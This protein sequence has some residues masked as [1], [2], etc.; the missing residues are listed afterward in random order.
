MAD[1]PL[2]PEA[3]DTRPHVPEGIHGRKGRSNEVP[4]CPVQ[5]LFLGHNRGA[6][7]VAGSV[8]TPIV[9]RPRATEEGL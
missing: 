1:A 8:A 9:A 5:E 3:L 7:S 4:P 6:R 2:K